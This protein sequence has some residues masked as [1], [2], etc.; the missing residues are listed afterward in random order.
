MME[1]S[2][3]NIKPTKLLFASFSINSNKEK[4]MECIES[5]KDKTYLT[6]K[7]TNQLTSVKKI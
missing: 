7:V 4:R 6:N 5:F 2:K 1:E 3:K